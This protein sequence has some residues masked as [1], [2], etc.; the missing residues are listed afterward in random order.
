MAKILIL[1]GGH[2]CTAPRPQKEADALTAAG[3]E[4]T[5]VGIWFDGE[6][7]TRDRTLL[8]QKKW[9][10]QPVLDFRPGQPSRFGVRLQAKLARVLYQRLRLKTPALLG[11]GARRLRQF[12]QNFQADLTIVHSEAGLWVGTELQRQGYR[13]GVDFED[14]FSRDLL[15]EARIT[16]PVAWIAALE[17][18]LNRTCPYRLTTSQVLAQALAEAHQVSPPTVVYN[19]FPHDESSHDESSHDKSPQGESCQAGLSQGSEKAL[20]RDS[21]PIQVHWFSQ[22]IGPGRGL[23]TLFAA[24]PYLNCLVEIHLRGHCSADTR[25]WLAQQI[26]LQWATHVHIHPTVAN[27]ELPARIAEHDIGLALEQRDPPSRNLTITNKLFQYLQA[28]LAV[29][30]TDT[31]GQREVFQQA[32]DIGHLVRCGDAIALAATIQDW[33]DHPAQLQ[34][35]KL[36]A[37]GA[38]QSHFSWEAQ[39]YTLLAAAKNAL[40]VKERE[41]SKVIAQATLTLNPSPWGEGL[42]PGSPSPQGERARG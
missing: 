25:T 6:M 23:E 28:G 41:S 7:V 21:E 34:A 33:V 13:V 3:H 15:P 9:A 18:H 40:Q 35:A 24:L 16:R 26:P 29:I 39:Q 14:W 37:Q 8:L 2:L 32:P 11:Y 4:V 38:I 19:V 36:A 30:A 17:A 27:H 5:V 12:A 31:A 20:S 42:Q 1:I 22:T 10:F